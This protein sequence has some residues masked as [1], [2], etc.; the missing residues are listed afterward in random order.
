MRKPSTWF[1]VIAALFLIWNIFG[2]YMYW[3]EATMSDIQYAEV[4]GEAS[5]AAREFYPTWAVAAFAVAVWGG[6]FAAILLLLRRRPSATVFLI[7]VVAAA[8][9]FIPVFASTPLREAGGSTFWLMPVIVV[10]IGVVQV[11]YA[12]RKI[13]DGT[14]R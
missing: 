7:S 13:A 9:C 5:A 10:V 1:W 4:Y 2:C 14:V 12:R 11:W 3:V 8:I 6:L